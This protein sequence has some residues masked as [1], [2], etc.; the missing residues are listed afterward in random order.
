MWTSVLWHSKYI[1]SHLICITKLILTHF[2]GKNSPAAW[3]VP[4]ESAYASWPAYWLG[5]RSVL[6]GESVLWITYY[7]RLSISVTRTPPAAWAAHSWRRGPCVARRPTPPASARRAALAQ[8]PR[9]PER[10]PW[11]TGPP[12]QSGDAVAGAGAYRTARR[13]ACR[14]ACVMLVSSLN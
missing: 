4:F 1:P 12:A 10:P 8:P 3:S 5:V 11:P 13:R 7:I 9:A 2:Y 14:A 6:I